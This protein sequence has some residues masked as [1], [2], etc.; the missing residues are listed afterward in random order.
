MGLMRLHHT[1]QF[2]QNEYQ[3]TQYMNQ[4]IKNIMKNK[5]PVRIAVPGVSNFDTGGLSRIVMH[6]NL[7]LNNSKINFD[8]IPIVEIK[9]IGYIEKIKQLGNRIIVVNIPSH[10]KVIKYIIYWI[11]LFSIIN[12]QY[13]ILHANT[14]NACTLFL[15]LL[16]AKI[17]GINIRIA[18]SHSSSI[19]GSSR[20]I[21]KVA[22]CICKPFIPFLATHYISCSSAA[23]KWM[24][25]KKVISSGMIH[26][27]NNG[28][29]SERYIIDNDK[30]QS[31][32][33]YLG[34]QADD[35]VIGH[36]GRFTYQ[37]NHHFLLETFYEIVNIKKNS[38][39]LLI[40]SGE[41]F[42]QT[43]EAAIKLEIH[44]NV[45]FYGTTDDV[46][47]LLNAM[48]YFVLPSWFEGLPIVAIES[49]ASGLPTLVSTNVSDEVC[50]TDLLQFK[51]LSDGSKEWAKKILADCNSRERR[52]RI[53]DIMNRGFDIRQAAKKL[54]EIYLTALEKI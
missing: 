39:L 26:T 9:N 50:I 51:S 35:F 48:D 19:D 27:I 33:D 1:G 49:Q 17:A 30:R 4:H 43:K 20:I 3:G 21:K 52:D 29:Y 10:N 8:Y 13:F 44:E 42:E 16:I 28:I 22:H 53:Q 37:K 5:Y 45:I 38:K 36:I 2:F 41:L 7:N 23:S 25:T 24:Y 40:G 11:K 15:Q 12:N 54:E 6:L 47:T 32:R 14:S 18:H 34:I 31:I 46:P